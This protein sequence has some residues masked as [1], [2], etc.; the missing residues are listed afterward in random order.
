VTVHVYGYG[1]D[2]KMG[3]SGLP[4]I[5]YDYNGDGDWEGDVYRGFV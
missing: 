1:G 2:L 4:L 3:E 5:L